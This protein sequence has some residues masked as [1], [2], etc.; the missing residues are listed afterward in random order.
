M[1]TYY[2][3][4]MGSVNSSDMMLYTYLGERRTV[5]Y[6]K[7]VAFNIIARVVLNSYIC[8]KENYRGSGKLKSRYTVSIIESLGRSGW[9]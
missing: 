3:K 8:Y 6:W 9:C 1:I 7:K 4:F 5:L 2:N